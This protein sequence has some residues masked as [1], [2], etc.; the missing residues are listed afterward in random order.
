VAVTFE[1]VEERT[2]EGR[3]EVGQVE[4]ARRLAGVGLGKA[5]QKP[6]VSR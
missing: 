5:D 2:D 1:V 3:V 6:E 4:L